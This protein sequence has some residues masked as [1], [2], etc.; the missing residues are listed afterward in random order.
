[1]ATLTYELTDY[2]LE[3]TR[4]SLNVTN[5][6]GAAAIQSAI[7]GVTFANAVQSRTYSTKTT[8]TSA[9]PSS[10][11]AQR[12]LKLLLVLADNVTGRNFTSTIGV[13]DANVLDT[14]PGTD[15]VNLDDSG[16][17]AALKAAYQAHVKSIEGNACSV[18]QA[19]I[20]GRNS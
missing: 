8:V 9:A 2:S 14:T 7:Q 13:I 3:P 4:T 17:G 16:V 20:V 18:L 15:V 6:T 11:Y 1:M 5:D 12:E 10:V 19:R